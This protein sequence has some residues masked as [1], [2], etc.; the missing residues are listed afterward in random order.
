MIYKK[1]YIDKNKIIYVSASDLELEE[2]G[3]PHTVMLRYMDKSWACWV[4]EERI[5]GHIVCEL[6]RGRTTFS[7]S[8][9]GKVQIGNRDG[10]RI[11][12]IDISDD[13]PNNLRHLRSAQKIDNYLY[14]TGMSNMLYRRGLRSGKWEKFDNGLRIPRSSKKIS[15]INSIGGTEDDK[16][17][18]CGLRGGLWGLEKGHWK[19]I[20]SGTNISLNSLSSLT[21]G[22]IYCCGQAGVVISGKERK[23]EIVSNDVTEEDFWSIVNFNKKI[24]ISTQSESLYEVIEGRVLPLKIN[25]NHEVTTYHLHTNNSILLS[26]GSRNILTYD[27]S[28]W[29][30]ITP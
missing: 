15:G 13:G 11:E 3:I 12:N 17:Y 10:F 14:A 28:S 8:N 9:N 6:E 25:I 27:G 5:V 22:D 2:K 29:V 23:W 26:V 1:G 4:I 18:A 30:D 7:V 21:S 24:F 16:I 19:S 20:E